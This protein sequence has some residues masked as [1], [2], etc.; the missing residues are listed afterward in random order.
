MNASDWI[1]HVV[2][3]LPGV[4]ISVA[5]FY[6]DRYEHEPWYALAGC[7]MLGALTTWPAIRIEQWAFPGLGEMTPGIGQTLL[8]AFAAV[9]LNEELWKLLAVL[10]GAWPWR[11]FNEPLDGIV[12][13]VLVAMGFATMENLVYADRFGLDAVVLRSLT[14]VPAHLLFALVLG[15]YLGLARFR[16]QKAPWLIGKGLLLAITLHGV[17]DFLILQRWSEWLLVLGTSGV[18][19]GIYYG[20]ILF[21]M[22][23]EKS[24]FKN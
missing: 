21:G 1:L 22:H 4:I 10:A 9:A 5:V 24:P 18:Y 17:Y 14:A 12:Y 16:P 23:L 2:A 13:A 15:Y 3:V 8:L 7:F 20:S 19:L 6:L 11:W